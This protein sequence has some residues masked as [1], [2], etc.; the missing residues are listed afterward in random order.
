MLYKRDI[1]YLVKDGDEGP[2]VVIVDEFTGRIKNA[3]AALVRRS[4]IRR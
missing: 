3:G 4:T 1:D 2:E